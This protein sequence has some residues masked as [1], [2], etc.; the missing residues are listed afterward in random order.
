[1]ARNV[2]LYVDSNRKARD[3]AWHHLHMHGKG[4]GLAGAFGG[5]GHPGASGFQ[6]CKPFDLSGTIKQQDIAEYLISED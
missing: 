3:V 6:L 4:G 1:M 2:A 5:G